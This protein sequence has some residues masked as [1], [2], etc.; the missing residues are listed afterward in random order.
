MSPQTPL[1][2]LTAL[3]RPLAGF[4]GAA[5]AAGQ[6]WRGRK[7]KDKWRERKGRG[8]KGAEREK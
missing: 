1:G 2:E 7:R 3:R 8:R 6:G 4:K 5:K